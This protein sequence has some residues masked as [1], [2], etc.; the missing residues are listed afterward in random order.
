MYNVTRKRY[1]YCTKI[2]ENLGDSLVQFIF[3]TKQF[4]LEIWPEAKPYQNLA[5]HIYLIIVEPELNCRSTDFV[6]RY[7]RN[8]QLSLQNKRSELFGNWN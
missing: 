2:F 7:F 6:A 8:Q 5:E 3:V 4:F 1:F